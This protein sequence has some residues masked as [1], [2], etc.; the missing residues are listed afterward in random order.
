[1]SSSAEGWPPRRSLASSGSRSSAARS[2]TRA[3]GPT[4]S[5]CTTRRHGKARPCASFSSSG[6]SRVGHS[7]VAAGQA[8]GALAERRDRGSN[9]SRDPGPSL[10]SG[11]S[12]ARRCP[13]VLRRKS[14]RTLRSPTGLRDRRISPSCTGFRARIG[15][16]SRSETS[17][18]R[19]ADGSRTRD[20]PRTAPSSPS[21]IIPAAGTVVRSVSWT[22]PARRSISRPG[23]RRSRASH[24]RR[25][26]RRSSSPRRAR[27]CSARSPR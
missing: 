5:P 12:R 25:V 18:T 16:S 13:E 3:S 14:S 6:Q 9:S 24:G 17:S 19:R 8:S 2:S 7:F 10:I 4:V 23:G 15:W 26:E 22:G 1:M 20:S 21:S 11:C 27:D